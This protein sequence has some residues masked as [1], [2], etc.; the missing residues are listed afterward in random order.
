MKRGSSRFE[1]QLVK[2][3]ALLQEA[4]KAHNPALYLFKNDARTSLFML[5]A[6]SRLYKELHNKKKFTKLTEQFKQLEDALGQIDYYDVYANDFLKHPMVPVHIREYMQGQAREKI[7]ALNEIL[8]NEKWLNKE[9]L[10]KI[11]KKLNKA[12]WLSSKMEMTGIK[13]FY[14]KE[15]KNITTLVKEAD[16]RFT[17]MENQVHEY[18]RNARWL[19]IYAQAMNGSI[20]LTGTE[21]SELNAKEYLTPEVINSKYNKLPEAGDNNWILLLDKNYFYALSWVI[22]ELGTIKDEGLQYFAVAEALQQTAGYNQQEAFNK[23]FEIF[24]VEKSSYENLLQRAG[25]IINK[26]TDEQHLENLLID[27]TQQTQES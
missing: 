12:D 16:G 4:S 5:E 27:V 8:V 7:Q 14:Q 10:L 18:R 13:K 25:N 26:F 23:S 6:L 15:I 9:R 21:L 19:S 17:E 3:E 1:N 20:Q 2:L 22:S 24:G 11:R